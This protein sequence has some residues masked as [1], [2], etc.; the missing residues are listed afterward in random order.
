MQE[1]EEYA[2]TQEESKTLGSSKEASFFNILK[3]P[4]ASLTLRAS[5]YAPS[6]NPTISSHPDK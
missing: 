5:S 6:P 4:L 3:E 1:E 2:Q